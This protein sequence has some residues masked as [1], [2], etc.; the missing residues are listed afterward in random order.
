MSEY[1]LNGFGER[2][3]LKLSVGEF[4]CPSSLVGSVGLS[5]LFILQES[6]SVAK[7]KTNE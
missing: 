5:A 1:S 2:K 3:N 7:E 4:V 6:V